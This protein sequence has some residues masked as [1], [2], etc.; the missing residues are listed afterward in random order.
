[1]PSFTPFRTAAHSAL[2][3]AS[4]SPR[5][6]TPA[7]TTLRQPLSTSAAP[8]MAYKDDQ[9]RNS[10]KPRAHEYTGSGT[11][12]QVANNADAAFNPDKTG[13]EEAMETASKGN[14]KTGS[15]DSGNPLDVSPANQEV[16]KGGQGAMEDKPQQ[17]NQNK[18]SGG[19]Q[20]ANKGGSK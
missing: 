10:V 13:P 1:M 8:R 2:R 6:A 17:G 9:D 19:A 14:K 4:R 7:T 12:E 18:K 5:T 15:G 3:L 16:S 11:D 20:T